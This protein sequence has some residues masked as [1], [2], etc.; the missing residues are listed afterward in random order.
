MLI[1]KKLTDTLFEL[2]RKRVVNQDIIDVFLTK[3]EIEIRE[4]INYDDAKKRD[5]KRKKKKT[6][7]ITHSIFSE[8]DTPKLFC[9]ERDR[10]KRT[11]QRMQCISKV[12]L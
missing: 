8:E 9:L 6:R 7:K 12:A 11:E 5:E 3:R 1:G 10:E 4:E 2:K